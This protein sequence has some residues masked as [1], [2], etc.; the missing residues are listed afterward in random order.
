MMKTSKLYFACL[1]VL[2][3]VGCGGDPTTGDGPPSTTKVAPESATSKPVQPESPPEIDIWTAIRVGNTKVVKQHLASGTDAN[4]K[5]PNGAPI[6]NAAAVYGHP[7][8]VDALVQKGANINGKDNDGNSALH[9]AAFLGR[10]EVVEYLLEKGVDAN[11][12]NNKSETPSD[13]LKVDWGTTQF[14][15]GLL[16]IQVNQQSVEANR[17]QSAALLA[18][19]G[20]KAGGGG[21]VAGGGGGLIGAIRKQNVAAVKQALAGGA[22]INAHGRQFGITPLNWA[23]LLGHVEIATLLIDK[24]ADVNGPNRDDG[25]RPLHSASYMGRTAVVELLLS[26]KADPNLKNNKGETPLVSATTGAEGIAFIGGLLQIK[27]DVAVITQGR[28][29]SASVLKKNGAKVPVSS[30]LLIGA[31]RK[32]DLEGVKKALADGEDPNGQD[33]QIGV[34]ALGWASMSGNV[35]VV[36]LLIKNRVNVN[37]KNRDGSTALHGAVFLGHPAIVELLLNSGIDVNAKNEDGELAHSAASADAGTTQFVAGLLQLKVDLAVVQ[38]GR[39]KC[40]ELLKNG[41]GAKELCAAVRKQDVATIKQLLAKPVDP[42]VQDPELGITA[43]AWAAYHGNAEIAGLL[44]AGKADVNGK[45]RDGSSPLHAAAFGG[46]AAVLELLLS[47]GADAGAKNA[48]GEIPVQSTEADA[49]TT[50][51]LAG[52]LQLKLDTKSLG[53]GRVRCVEL[54]KK[55]AGSP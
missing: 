43:L 31:V 39:A 3:V 29:K 55:K 11:I 46:H 44:I 7:E 12:K 51:V 25:T 41:T 38:K 27:V 16:Q 9:S 40:L 35:E 33:A 28:A 4:S 50:R 47:K 54:L 34:T 24:G 22:N 36:R 14:V 8:I 13:V 48:D 1:A 21:G 26:K 32:R 5:D 2:V 45:S 37:G 10:T 20:G 30:S 15:A 18:K 42:N 19:R 23:S 52:L 49:A 6:L 53:P 17:N